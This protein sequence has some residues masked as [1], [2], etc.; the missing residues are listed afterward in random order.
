MFKKIMLLLALIAVVVAVS[1]YKTTVQDSRLET[2]YNEGITEANQNFG[3]L[4]SENDSLSSELQNR[5]TELTEARTALDTIRV[6]QTDSLAN[7]VEENNRKLTELAENNT[8]KKTEATASK[9]DTSSSRHRE[10]LTYYKKM[11]KDLPKD[12]SAYE[13]RIAL[14][15]IRQESASK[16]QITVA[17]LN[18]IRQANNL[19][20]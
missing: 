15:E 18:E 12:L 20:Y 6:A 9:A 19:S 11:Y 8:E 17:K 4:Q 13:R 5:E 16:F 7:L 14:S 1:Y 3:E 10:I 2:A